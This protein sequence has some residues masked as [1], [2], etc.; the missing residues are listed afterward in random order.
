MS[1]CSKGEQERQQILNNGQISTLV[2]QTGNSQTT[3]TKQ[4]KSLQPE[5]KRQEQ[6]GTVCL[7]YCALCK[8][9]KH[10]CTV[11]TAVADVRGQKKNVFRTSGALLACW[12]LGIAAAVAPTAAVPPCRQCSRVACPGN[13][14][15]RKFP[16]MEQLKKMCCNNNF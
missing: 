13:R 3:R 1:P 8:K 10:V 2:F 16:L 15:Q 9:E 7:Y 11:L 12:L 5:T 14:T 6:K 4:N